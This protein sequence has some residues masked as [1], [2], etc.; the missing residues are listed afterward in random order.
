MYLQYRNLELI[1]KSGRPDEDNEAI[2]RG[3]YL[4]KSTTYEN[5]EDYDD[6]DEGFPQSVEV[7][8]VPSKDEMMTYIFSDWKVGDILVIANAPLQHPKRQGDT[9]VEMTR[10]E[11]CQ[12]GDLSVLTDGEY[13][14]NEKI[15]KI[16]YNQKFGYLRPTWDKELKQWIEKATKDEQLEYYKQEILKNTRELLV[17]EKSG[18]SND[19]LQKKIDALVEK[20]RILSEEIA[21]NYNK[22]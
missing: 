6:I 12:T 9:L 17:F 16:E 13:F 21:M 4:D 20:H 11:I 10:E 19:E 18:F 7:S 3:D 2:L 15:I 5:Q 1:E 8:F 22:E 14:E